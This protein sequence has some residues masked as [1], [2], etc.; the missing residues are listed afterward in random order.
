MTKHRLKIAII[1]SSLGGGGAQKS[2]A[3]LSFVLSKLDYDVHIISI[4]NQIDYEYKGQ[5]LNLG[6]F[7][8][9]ND[10]IFGK[11]KRFK[12]FYNYLKSENFDYIIDS[13]SRPTFFKQFLINKILYSN[14]NVIYIIHSYLLNNYFP[15]NRFLARWL[16]NNAKHL[17]CVSNDI[18]DLVIHKFGLK[19][20][21][22]MYN[23][24]LSHN[25]IPPDY[26]L[27]LPKNFILFFGRIDDKVK[28]ISLLLEA[29]K[30]SQLPNK[31][32]ELVILGDGPDTLYLKQK[33]KDLEL[34]DKVTFL[35]YLSDPKAIISKAIFT[36]LTSTH[37][38]FPMVVI[39]S[40]HLGVP[41]VSVDCKSGPS[42]VINHK[43]NGLLVDNHN[44]I[45]LA[46]AF[47]E[48]IENKKLYNHCKEQAKQSV[49]KFSDDIISKSW[50]N[51][52]K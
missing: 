39:E 51:L 14:Q 6:E 18:K 23:A 22:T 33:V 35:S 32:I 25:S 4:L 44:P 2:S 29:F 30:R 34:E 40:L 17:L 45:A 49:E 26:E 48:F 43:E 13:R 27:Q 16:Y 3:N 50:L 20:T 8:D 46:D 15:S 42:E 10:S 9:Q 28:N 12:L 7:K 31:N 37:E 1:T 41:V 11:I 19:A 5:L 52:L 47:N 38:G 36:T 24:F 21:K